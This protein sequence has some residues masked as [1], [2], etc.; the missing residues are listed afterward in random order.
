MEKEKGRRVDNFTLVR[1]EHLNH[2]GYLFGGQM[3]K[4]VDEL[5]WLVASLDFPGC[6]MVTM[7]LDKIVFKER[8]APGSILRFNVLPVRQ[9]ASS[10]TYSVVVY[11]DE[12]GADLEKIVFTTT[13]TFVRVDATGQKTPLPKVERY[14]SE[15]DTQ[16][17]GCP[18]E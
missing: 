11:A 16:G 5:A 9:G 13:I 15:C 14:R 10:I 8:V 7:A 18:G 4:W 3:L 12:P 17:C 1:P 6:S 2:H